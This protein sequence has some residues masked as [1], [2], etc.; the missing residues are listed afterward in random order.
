PVQAAAASVDVDTGAQ[1]ATSRP[2]R[3][4]GNRFV[5]EIVV[6][7]QKREENLQDVPISIQA[8]T[9]D[10]L[11][12][13]GIEDPKALQLAT[14]G[15]QYSVVGGYSVVYLR[16]VGTD[17]FVPSA[18]PS[19]ATYIDGVYYAF[20]HGLA[21]ALGSVERVEVLKGPQGT[22]FGRNSTG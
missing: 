21:Q 18:D 1:T 22:L 20:G 6:T 12:A 15:L 7:A 4:S 14:P 5:D 10:M 9:A 11:S 3:S 16:G 8:F 13:R 19:V 17:A 2:A